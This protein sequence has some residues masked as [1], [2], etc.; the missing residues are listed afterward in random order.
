MNVTVMS[1]SETVH[2]IG[3]DLP[4]QTS[5]IYCVTGTLLFMSAVHIASSL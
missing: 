1:N 5:R 3:Y 4:L 2:V